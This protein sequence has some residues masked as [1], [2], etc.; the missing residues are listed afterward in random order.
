MSY[1][2][3]HQ[4]TTEPCQ[5]TGSS[6]P[7]TSPITAFPEVSDPKRAALVSQIL[8][9]YE[10]TSVDSITWA[11]VWLADLSAL[12][13][14]VEMS[15]ITYAKQMIQKNLRAD[16]YPL[17]KD[18]MYFLKYV[19]NTEETNYLYSRAFKIQKPDVKER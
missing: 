3:G 4:T 12:E 16:F 5:K 19:A 8:E 9:I 7:P 13:A 10:V 2:L 1:S 17:L 6:S 14:M 11:L 18:C 15:S